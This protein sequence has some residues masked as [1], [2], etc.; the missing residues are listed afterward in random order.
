MAN[1]IIDATLRFVDDFTRPMNKALG[2]MARHSSEFT[3][4][5]KNITKIGE[6]IHKAG[7]SLTKTATVPIVGMGVA[8]VKTAAD[9]ESG[10][11]KVQSI[12]GANSEDMGI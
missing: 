10:M 11:S 1:K 9:F 4:A 8:A 6:N 3:N 5:G 7:S 12:C 2:T